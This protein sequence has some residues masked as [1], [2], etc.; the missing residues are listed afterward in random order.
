MVARE[1]EGREGER[2]VLEKEKEG[3]REEYIL[4][5]RIRVQ[6]KSVCCFS[7]SPFSSSSLSSWK[8]GKDSPSLSGGFFVSMTVY[9]PLLIILYFIYFILLK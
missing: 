3:L 5:F 4:F 1:G 6:K 8:M 7:F 2:G 9:P